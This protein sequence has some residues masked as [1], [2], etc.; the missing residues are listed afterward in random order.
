MVL[1]DVLLIINVLST[2]VRE[3]NLSIVKPEALSVDVL[4]SGVLATHAKSNFFFFNTFDEL[5]NL[6]WT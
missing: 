6:L 3:P 5:I 4:T 2:K 1:H